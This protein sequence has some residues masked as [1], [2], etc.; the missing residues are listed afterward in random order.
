MNGLKFLGTLRAKRCFFRPFMGAV[1]FSIL[2]SVFIPHCWAGGNEDEETIGYLKELSMEALLDVEVTSVSKKIEKLSDAS[3]AIFVITQ[4]DI[5]RSGVTTIPEALRM[6]P[7]L[8]VARID[9]SKWAIT[10]RG[11]NGRFANKLLVLIDGRSVYTPLYSGVFWEVQDTLLEDIDRIEVI[12]GPGA[13]L[14][15][16]NAVNG[17]INI[18]TKEAKETQGGLLA[19]GIGTEEK[20]FGNARYGG[21][22]GEDAYFRIYG[23]YFNRDE[24][25]DALGNDAADEWDI[26]RGGFRMDW[27]KSDYN[28][29]TVQGDT[30]E[31]DAGQTITIAT[32]TS[33]YEETLDEDAEISGKN[34]LFRWNHDISKT[35]ELVL[36]TYYDGTEHKESVGHLNNDTFD[37]DLQH[38]FALGKQHEIMWGVGYRFVH[39]E[40]DGTFSAVLEP[41]SRDDHLYSSFIQD[42]IELVKDRLHLTIGSKF[43]HNDYTGLE[44][45]PN[46]RLIWTPHER[47]SLWTSVSRAVRTPSRAEQDG[48]LIIRVVPPE[49]SIPLPTYLVL[50]GSEDYVSEDLIAYELGYRVQTADNFSIDIVAF[51]NDYD[52]LRSI[53]TGTYS[54]EDS[55]ILS[56]VIPDNK[57]NGET[58]GIELAM[59]WLAM[60]W[61]RFKT[62]YTY[63]Q[64]KLQADSDSQDTYSDTVENENPHNQFSIRSS[65]DLPGSFEFDVWVRYVDNLSSQDVD[66]YTTFDAR[67]GWRPRKNLELCIVGQNL[68]DK[69]HPEFIPE[70]LDVS[71]TEVEQS[72]YGKVTWHF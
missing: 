48:Q 71:T 10:S 59:D 36:Q 43:E 70:L 17:V 32:L 55:Y 45:Q 60:E 18:I 6:V 11:F 68:L 46:G 4:E 1:L 26:L 37:I 47:H 58:Y 34:L 29:I 12:R 15:G 41:E 61:W 2:F 72:V 44:I 3:A 49:D 21:K 30:Y 38:R 63:L 8:Q 64:M 69:Q 16:A 5:R 42:E 20:G 62:S 54:V 24:S 9:G 50:T 22:L 13:T 56:Y 65:M 14:W 67:L 33:P 66:S 52:D 31:G 40:I 23:K 28:S 57:V 53:E 27:K 39:D 25:A 35:S 19:A 7:G 51:F